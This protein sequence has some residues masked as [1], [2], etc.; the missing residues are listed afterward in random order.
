VD[1]TLVDAAPP[2]S[3]AIGKVLAKTGTLVWFDIM[4]N[5]ELLT[6]KALAGTMTTAK[7]RALTVALYVNG[8]PLP[9]GVAPSREG[10]VLGK[11]CDIIY[12]YAP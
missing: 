5:R 4:N 11:L 2:G 7:G 6:S 10:K 12:Q 3:P 1:G 8:V 9:R